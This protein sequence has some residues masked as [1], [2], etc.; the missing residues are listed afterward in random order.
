MPR[1]FTDSKGLVIADYQTGLEKKW[2]EELMN[3]R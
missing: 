3:I 2:E 1:S